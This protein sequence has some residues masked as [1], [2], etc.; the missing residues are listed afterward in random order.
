MPAST[1][2]RPTC[3]TS[4][5][6]LCALATLGP[7]RVDALPDVPTRAET[8]LG[9]EAVALTGVGVPQGTPSEVIARLNR[10]IT[11]GLADPGLRKRFDDLTVTPLIFT[12]AEFGANMAS[13]T[14]KW[15]K[16]IKSAGIKAEQHPPVKGPL[17]SNHQMR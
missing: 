16:V 5:P 12:P 6:A 3:R 2:S 9:Y 1:W 10:E 17:S 4:A 11:A 15:A 14:E 8:F 13:E 7:K